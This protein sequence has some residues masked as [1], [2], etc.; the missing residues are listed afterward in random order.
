MAVILS[1]A[2]NQPPSTV[3]SGSVPATMRTGR[4]KWTFTS[5]VAST[6]NTSDGAAYLSLWDFGGTTE[7]W[8]ERS[9]FLRV[10]GT[11]I[12]RYI[13][14]TFGASQAITVELNCPTGDIVISGATTGN[15]TS[16]GSPFSFD[17]VSTLYIGQYRDGTG[18]FAGTF[19]DVE[20]FAATPITGVASATMTAPTV[21]AAGALQNAG[22]S[23]ASVTGPTAAAS[24][25]ALG[26]SGTAS[27]SV[28]APTA[29]AL[30]SQGATSISGTASAVVTGPTAAGA[31]GQE[32]R[33]GGVVLITDPTASA[34]GALVI[35][36]AAAA[37]V[38]APTAAAFGAF[39]APLAPPAS[40][41]F[42]PRP[43][44]PQRGGATYTFKPP[45]RES[46]TRVRWRT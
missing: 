7:M 35:T 34:T 16:A 5:N 18:L 19:G 36:G 12:D 1:L 44:G 21:A 31:G 15:G 46:V 37:S 23:S 38:T 32:H 42:L 30:G 24:G 10:V 40:G 8:H 33:G 29:A 6:V 4:W 17:E 11:G 39:L 27:A 43:T 26:I 28:T 20:D 14:C 41:G 45:R 3:A 22:T 2:S 13:P 9:G 25:G